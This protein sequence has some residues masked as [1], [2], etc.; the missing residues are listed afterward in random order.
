[1]LNWDEPLSPIAPSK[2]EA[3][4]GAN[5][6]GAAATVE[7]P[8]VSEPPAAELRAKPTS[9]KSIEPTAPIA[10]TPASAKPINP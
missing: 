7:A 4:I 9:E 6:A 3:I 10:P 2:P 1:M 8:M 5:V